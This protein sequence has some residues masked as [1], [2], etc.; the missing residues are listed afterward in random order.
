MATNAYDSLGDFEARLLEKNKIQAYRI[1]LFPHPSVFFRAVAYSDVDF[2]DIP[3]AAF[4][5][6]HAHVS[7]SVLN[8]NTLHMLE[9]LSLFTAYIKYCSLRKI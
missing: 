9:W 8:A 4:C 6:K 1:N 5:C 3:S 2:A 7:V